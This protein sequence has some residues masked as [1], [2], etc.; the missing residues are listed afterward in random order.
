MSKLGRPNKSKL[1]GRLKY[2]A[3]LLPED[4]YRLEE[5]CKFSGVYNKSIIIRA[6]LE[7]IYNL[8]LEGRANNGTVRR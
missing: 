3:S 1:G 8:Y 4:M 2:T 5:L 6:A 7:I